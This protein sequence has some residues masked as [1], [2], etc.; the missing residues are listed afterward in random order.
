MKGIFPYGI[1][2]DEAH[3]EECESRPGYTFMGWYA[4]AEHSRLIFRRWESSENYY[5]EYGT[6]LYGWWVSN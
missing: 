2:M 3:M 4:D 6:T 5:G 1:S